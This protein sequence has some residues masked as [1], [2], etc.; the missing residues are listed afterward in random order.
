LDHDVGGEAILENQAK[1]LL[2]IVTLVPSLV[3]L[4]MPRLLFLMRKSRAFQQIDPPRTVA[5]ARPPMGR[6]S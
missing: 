3:A 5:P 4:P 6:T 1:S 2:G